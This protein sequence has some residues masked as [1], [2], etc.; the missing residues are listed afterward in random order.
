MG[1]DILKWK[2]CR[3]G[4]KNDLQEKYQEAPGKRKIEFWLEGE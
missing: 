3:D 2:V 4:M 1:R